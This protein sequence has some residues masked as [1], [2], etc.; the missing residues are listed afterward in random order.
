MKRRDAL[1]V[2][3]GPAGAAAAILLAR[4]GWNVALAEK[5]VFPRRKVC[6]EFISAAA[7]PL[8]EK[9]GVGAAIAEQ[10]GPA[11]GTVGF[12]AR[13]AAV[14]APMP[15]SIGTGH[16][17]GREHLDTRLLEH[18]AACGAEILQPCA[19]DD[20]APFAARVVIA[21]HGSW[22][23][24]SLP[25]QSARRRTR[26]SDLLGFKAHFRS[27]SLAPGVMPLLVFPGGY[28][29]LVQ[30]DGGRVSLS[31]CVR[32]DALAAARRAHRGLSAGDA[33]LMHIVETN[34]GVREAL[35]T[36]TR[37]ET[38]LAAGP[39]RPGIRAFRRGGVFA[40]G[41][42]AGEAHPIVAEG[43]SM[44]IQSSFLLCERLV[45][46][47]PSA[48]EAA[49][50]EAAAAYERAWRRNFAPRV[51][52]AAFFAAAL[53]RPVGALVAEQLLTRMPAVLTLGASWSG[54]DRSLRPV[55][56]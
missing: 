48:G 7:W 45:R 28:G 19:V 17:I 15:R 55:R 6:G 24:G 23:P 35:A 30:S 16:A 26:A 9:L 50:A 37:E 40:V 5:A 4:A 42:A 12:F 49:L 44:A 32:R 25:T 21:A 34:R 51:R 47:G 11:V 33:L 53:T 39:V 1:V 46:A 18:A 13:H 52:A 10:A 2:G 27:A 41:N 36:A 54:K 43:I 20:P 22:E 29:G 8:I 14:G 31:C 56:A 38:W 3:G